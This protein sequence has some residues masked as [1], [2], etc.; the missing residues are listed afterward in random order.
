MVL[1]HWIVIDILGIS[2]FYGAH[3]FLFP[4]V[5]ERLRERGAADTLV[6]G[7]GIIPDEDITFLREKGISAV[8][9]PGSSV[10]AI[11]D[12]IRKSIKPK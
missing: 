5:V 8:F 12:I 10:K 9:G 7:G 2:S 11:A 6:I 4:R 3:R 1:T